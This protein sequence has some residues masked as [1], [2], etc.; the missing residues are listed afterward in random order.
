M[1]KIL[2]P[3]QRLQL[4][5]FCV[6]IDAFARLLGHLRTEQLDELAIDLLKAIADLVAGQM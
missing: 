4:L 5:D 2:R 3:Q 1:G 6:Q